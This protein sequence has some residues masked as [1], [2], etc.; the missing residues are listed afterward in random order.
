[1][2]VDSRLKVMLDYIA[3]IACREGNSPLL[4]DTHVMN[5]YAYEY[6]YVYMCWECYNYYSSQYSW[7][8]VKMQLLY[9]TQA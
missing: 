5:V 2:N 9:D 3:V 7:N 1:M 8:T 4:V 6:V